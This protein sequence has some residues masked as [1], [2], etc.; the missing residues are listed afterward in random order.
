[1]RALVLVPV[2][3]ADRARQTLTARGAQRGPQR[4][5]S[6]PRSSADRLEEAVGLAEAIDLDVTGGLVVPVP[7]PRPATLFGSGK[8]EEITRSTR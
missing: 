7:Q 1:M 8:V 2:L 4:P 5:G 3:S 6:L